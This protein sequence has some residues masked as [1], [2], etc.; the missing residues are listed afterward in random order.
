MDENLDILRG[1]DYVGRYNQFQI[2]SQRLLALDFSRHWQ[3]NFRIVN[4]RI[5]TLVVG[6]SNISNAGINLRAVFDAF[7]SKVVRD[8][9]IVR[10]SEAAL[11]KR[12]I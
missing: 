6:L 4:L 5:D 2:P 10:A 8:S 11:L 9:L 1:H 12:I 3:S 7:L